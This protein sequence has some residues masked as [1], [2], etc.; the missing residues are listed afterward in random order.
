LFDCG[1]SCAPHDIGVSAAAL[2]LL[3]PPL[4]LLPR[5]AAGAG[6][7]TGEPARSQA[8]AAPAAPA[9]C[10]MTASDSCAVSWSRP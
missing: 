3:L 10:C 6:G 9:K 2:P 1:V 7:G 8:G 5:R 4:L